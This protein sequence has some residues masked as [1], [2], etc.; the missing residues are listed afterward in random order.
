MGQT[1]AWVAWVAW[2]CKV[3]AWITEKRGW[4]ESKLWRGWRGSINF[5]VNQKKDVGDVDQNFG[6]VGVGP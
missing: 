5:G 4:C 1:L 2:I 6:G 3:L